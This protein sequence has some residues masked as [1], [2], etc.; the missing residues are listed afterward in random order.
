MIF[1]VVMAALVKALDQHGDL[2]RMAIA[3]PGNDFRLGACEAPPAIMST[4]LGPDMT[5]YLDAYKNASG[6]GTG[7]DTDDSTGAA[8][9]PG[10]KALDMGARMLA[11][12]EVRTTPFFPPPSSFLPTDPDYPFPCDARCLRRT[13]T[14]H[15][16]SRT[17][18][19]GTHVYI[20]SYTHAYAFGHCVHKRS[21]SYL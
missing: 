21:Q 10:V 20:Y 6:D 12:V 18:G 5:A 16:P 8:Y 1:P 4:F 15:R 7:S 19:T 3:S 14:A 11:P 9:S 17:G 13:V 2:L